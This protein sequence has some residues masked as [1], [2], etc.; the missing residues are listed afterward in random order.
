M[1]MGVG[2]TRTVTRLVIAVAA[3]SG[4]ASMAPSAAAADT[5][6]CD[7]IAL[8]ATIL[9][10]API[11][12]GTAN[13]GQPTCQS[14]NGTAV[15]IP[16][17]L[18]LPISANAVQAQTTVSTDKQTA[19]AI[20][21][22]GSLSVGLGGTPLAQVTGPIVQA[23]TGNATPVPLALGPIPTLL[24]GLIPSSATL[25]PAQLTAGGMAI[26]AALDNIIANALNAPDAVHADA[27]TSTATAT[28]TN[29]QPQLSGSSHVADLKV[30]GQD[31]PLTAPTSTLLNL[32]NTTQLGQLNL[33]GTVDTLTQQVIA[34]LGLT[35]LAATNP[36]LAPLIAQFQAGLTQQIGPQIQAALQT[37]LIQLQAAINMILKLTVEANKQ[38]V[39]G[40]QLT[41]QAL[42]VNLSLTLPGMPVT[43]ILD[44][45]IGQARVSNA[46][47]A[48]APPGSQTSQAALACSKR[49]LTLINVLQHGNHT[50]IEGAAKPQLVG[51]TIPIFFTAS[52]RQVAKAKVL[53]NGFFRTTAPLPPKAIRFTNSARYFARSGGETTLKLKFHRRMI[54]SGTTVGGG[55]VHIR[56]HIER[57]LANPIARIIIQRRVSCTQTVDVSSVKPSKSGSFSITVAAPPNQQVGVYRA[58]TVVR[59]NTRNPRRFPTFTLPR[60]IT[61]S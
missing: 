21:G 35:Q 47:V 57:P 58:K 30:L 14:A 37:V 16:T 59:K 49:N 18:G 15:S 41:Q 44:I 43:P 13:L 22:I 60:F 24:Q 7:A 19:T 17:G 39:A 5:F 25:T 2:M 29:N 40:G 61:L 48:C 8:Q 51:Q 1:L 28:C 12:L 46:S 50:F 53:P 23:I 6:N 45:L 38:T 54:V 34:S 4:A 33:A 26:Q 27:L 55:Q 10:A 9:T 20:G 3:V 52:H 32:F 31:I 36:L 56:G 42:H 11:Q